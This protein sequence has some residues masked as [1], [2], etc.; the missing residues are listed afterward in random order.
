MTRKERR[1][2]SQEQDRF[3]VRMPDGMRD[4]IAK[5]AEENGRS[6]NSEIVYRL[7]QSFLSSEAH[8]AIDEDPALQKIAQDA[9]RAAVT[10]MLRRLLDAE[11][12]AGIDQKD[13]TDPIKLALM[14]YDDPK[15][16]MEALRAARKS[17]NDEQE[18][19]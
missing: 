10:L 15:K 8:G 19:E 16:L 1:Y 4:R 6:M 5:A 12:V 7:E 13:I 17:G 18:P 9:A 14:L 2:P 11:D 3:I